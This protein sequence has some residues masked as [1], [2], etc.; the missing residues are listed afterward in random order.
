MYVEN[1]YHRVLLALGRAAIH[2][3]RR[4]KRNQIYLR[5]LQYVQGEL[6]A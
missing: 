6:D 2:L 3:K 5:K 4:Y 1:K